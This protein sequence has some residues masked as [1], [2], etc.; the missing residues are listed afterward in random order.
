MTKY[1]VD[2]VSPDHR[3]AAGTQ[4]NGRK[5]LQ[6]GDERAERHPHPPHPGHDDA[7]G[8]G[9]QDREDEAGDA[10]LQAGHQRRLMS[11]RPQ[12]APISPTT[13]SGLGTMYAG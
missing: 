7:D 13:S 8:R 2:S 6:T 4:A 11:P 10:A 1:A 3:I 9:H 5:D 12:D